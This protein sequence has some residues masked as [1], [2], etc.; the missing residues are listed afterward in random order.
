MAS[1]APQPVLTGEKKV[2][3]N[4]AERHLLRGT[5]QVAALLVSIISCLLTISFLNQF[6]FR[7]HRLAA[8]FSVSGS[9][10][11]RFFCI[12]LGLIMGI[13]VKH[14]IAGKA[15][16]VLSTASGVIDLAASIYGAWIMTQ[17]D[18]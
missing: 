15:A 5:L 14:T 17:F 9:G 2:A 8:F 7:N 12:V 13:R 11:V 10:F 6:F 1:M 18:F 4:D 16:I 3:G